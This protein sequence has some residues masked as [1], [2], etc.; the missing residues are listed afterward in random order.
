MALRQSHHFA[1]YKTTKDLSGRST[2]HLLNPL[3]TLKSLGFHVPHE[4]SQQ[5]CLVDALE[6]SLS[7]CAI[8]EVNVPHGLMWGMSQW[9]DR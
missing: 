5:G 3:S 4:M 1:V 8:P 2:V 6:T 9:Q 7:W